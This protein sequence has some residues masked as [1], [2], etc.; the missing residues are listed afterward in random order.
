MADVFLVACTAEI[1]HGVW[2]GIWLGVWKVT[3]WEYWKGLGLN[4]YFLQLNIL[5]L[6][7]LQNKKQVNF[8]LIQSR[9]GG[10]TPSK[11]KRNTFYPPAQVTDWL[12]L[13][14]SYLTSKV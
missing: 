7:M 1:W 4:I 10:M 3:G 13:I 14:M 9:G 11:V 2:E 12:S 8:G 5:H 6:G